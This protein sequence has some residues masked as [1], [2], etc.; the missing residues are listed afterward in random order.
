MP[1]FTLRIGRVLN[2]DPLRRNGILAV[3]P[4]RNDAFQIA[5]AYHSIKFGT[6]AADMVREQ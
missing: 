3:L 4:F 2:L 6:A 5:L 1:A